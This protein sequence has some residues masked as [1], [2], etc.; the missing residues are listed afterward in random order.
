MRE[1]SFSVT[2]GLFFLP[3][4]KLGRKIFARIA[5]TATTPVPTRIGTVCGQRTS[6]NVLNLL[7]SN[8]V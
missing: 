6:F 1:E 4:N 7:I 5:V 3:P 2:G 8:F